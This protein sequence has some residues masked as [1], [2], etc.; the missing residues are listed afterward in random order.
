MSAIDPE[1]LARALHERHP[2]VDPLTAHFKALQSWI[3]QL[4]PSCAAAETDPA[5]LEAVQSAWYRLYCRRA[6]TGEDA[7]VR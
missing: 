6:G 7:A 2:D 1:A 5:Q 4:E 3:N